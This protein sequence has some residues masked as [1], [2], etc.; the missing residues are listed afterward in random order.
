MHDFMLL[1]DTAFSFLSFK[2]RRE[3][4]VNI[5]KGIDLSQTGFISYNQFFEFV[6]DHMTGRSD[7]AIR[8]R[9]DTATTSRDSSNLTSS[10]VHSSD[11]GDKS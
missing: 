1:M 2:P 3:D 7:T 9:K 11:E 10:N 8:S 6:R 4:L 5:F